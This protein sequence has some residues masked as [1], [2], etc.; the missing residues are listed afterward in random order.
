MHKSKK[1]EIQTKNGN[2]RNA[3]FTIHE[4]SHTLAN[5]VRYVLAHD[6]DVNFV[7]YSVPHP[8]EFK[9]NVRV[10]TQ[11]QKSS[12]ERFDLA[13]ENLCL[14]TNSIQDEF[15]NK[16]EKFKEEKGIQKE[17]VDPFVISLKRQLRKEYKKMKANI[18]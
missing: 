8:S 17:E 18:D 3:T 7:G 14:V 11:Q 1:L 15:K 9:V 5:T 12:I 10:Q 4:E 6:D 2:L 13:L 16:L